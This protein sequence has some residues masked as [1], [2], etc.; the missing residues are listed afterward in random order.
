LLCDLPDHKLRKG[1]QCDVVRVLQNSEGNPV[2]IELSWF[3]DRTSQTA[4]IPING[5][6]PVLSSTTEQW[7][8]VFWGL[9]KLPEEF[10][11]ASLHCVMDHG[12]QMAPGLNAVQVHHDNRERGWKWGEPLSDPAGTYIATAGARW[13][14]CVAA[15]S[16]PQ[17]F[18]V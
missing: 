11:E 9:S 12:F 13:D 8:A 18:H 10:I 2:E 16:G 17:R 14:G 1:Q 15:F 7:T 4:I 3:A 5:V 6:Q